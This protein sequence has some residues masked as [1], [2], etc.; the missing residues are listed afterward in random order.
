MTAHDVTSTDAMNSEKGH[1]KSKATPR[2][3]IEK[4]PS[5]G[6][7]ATS[8]W[9]LITN[10]PPMSHLSDLLPGLSQILDF[11]LQKGIIDLDALEGKCKTSQKEASEALNRLNVSDSF[12]STQKICDSDGIPLWTPQI[13]PEKIPKS[14]NTYSNSLHNQININ[15]N[16]AAT[17]H[18]TDVDDAP[19]PKRMILEA[20]I[21]LSYRA[22]PLGWFLRFPNRSVV[23]AI[24]NHVKEAE[25]QERNANES[26]EDEEERL[27]KERG[28]WREGLWKEVWN[29]HEREASKRQDR[30][31]RGL[32]DGVGQVEAE[33]DSARENALMWGDGVEEITQEE[34]ERLN[35]MAWGDR[36]LE[37]TLEGSDRKMRQGLNHQGID[38]FDGSNRM[39]MNDSSEGGGMLD[40]TEN[41]NV[42]SS[43]LHEYLQ[44]HPYPCH[45]DTASLTT[46]L[47]T[48][49]RLLTCGSTTLHVQEFHPH[50]SDG[51]PPSPV[52]SSNKE[53]IPWEKYSF[54]IGPLLNISD[55]VVRVETTALKTTVEDIHYLFRSYD[56]ESIW[57]V[58]SS[59][60]SDSSKLSPIS[61]ILP[62]FYSQFPKSIGWYHSV[63][64]ASKKKPP[65]KSAVEF[66][67]KGSCGK[68]HGSNNV[69]DDL[70]DDNDNSRERN[71]PK[72][73]ERP[74][75]HTFLV[76]FASPADARMAVRDKQGIE[77]NHR[78]LLV[79]QFPRQNVY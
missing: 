25:R 13:P 64:T 29:H 49:Y 24:L 77:Y 5:P 8:E 43:Y 57:P 21:H 22:R 67:L 31:V 68:R 42:I 56:L 26:Q 4:A 54:Q 10:V 16:G 11:E 34:N 36:I 9:I 63:I 58:P 45:S 35:H 23:N 27:R 72:M 44:S 39:T 32:S 66:L 19:F 47:L 15:N 17:I 78:R 12:Y 61:P 74:S 70:D 59:P 1:D 76:R 3:K 60:T 6:K 20:R 50:S 30:L 28:E 41:Q 55:S 37:K 79:L 65:P 38:R 71:S 73:V 7:V 2:K 18:S 69:T 52:G 46:R 51:V 40:G 62:L 53:Q 33:D 75:K 14:F 48:D